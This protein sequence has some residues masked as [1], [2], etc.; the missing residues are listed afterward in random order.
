MSLYPRLLPGFLALSL[1]G[2][3]STDT[4]MT[5]VSSSAKINLSS[6]DAEI[7]GKKIWQN[8][9]GG[10]VDGLTSWNSGENFPSLGIGHFIWYPQGSQGPF[11]ESFPKLIVFMRQKGLN[12]PQW[13]VEAQGSPWVSR[14]QFMAEKNSPK[15]TELRSFLASTVST[16]T[17]FIVYRLEQALPKMKTATADL[18]DKARLE[19]NFYKVAGTRSGVYSLIDYVNFK[20][21]GVKV[22]ERYNGQGWGLRDV[23]LEMGPTTGGQSSVNEFSEA[24]KRVLQRRVKNSPPSRGESRW[25]SGWMN[26]CEGYKRGI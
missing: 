2:C 5:P 15:M 20:G 24:A 17:D 8:E 9:C 14:T 16:Q 12:V 6:S 4:P 25:L 23:L 1:A 11:D 3:V 21:E 7:I 26:R 22:E 19:E 18:A 10:T 13:L